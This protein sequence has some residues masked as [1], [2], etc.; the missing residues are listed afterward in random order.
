MIDPVYSIGVAG[1]GIRRVRTSLQGKEHNYVET[2]IPDNVRKA[3]VLYAKHETRVWFPATKFEQEN[4]ETELITGLTPGNH[5]D[6]GGYWC[7]NGA[8]Q[9]VSLYWLLEKITSE[10]SG[11][12]FSGGCLQWQREI[13]S[14]LEEITGNP[15][16]QWNWSCVDGFYT[17]SKNL[18]SLPKR[19]I[20]KVAKKYFGPTFG[21]LLGKEVANYLFGDQQDASELERRFDSFENLEELHNWLAEKGAWSPVAFYD[22]TSKPPAIQ[23]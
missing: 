16:S 1:Q 2:S 21:D 9:Y 8:F 7:R 22:Y 4:P 18:L 12:P 13:D 14:Q 10:N 5:S 3:V 6:A 11:D 20:Q 19:G 23:A 17:F 15:Q